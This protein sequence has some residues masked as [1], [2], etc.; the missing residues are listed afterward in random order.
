MI[1]YLNCII[2]LFLFSPKNIGYQYKMVYWKLISFWENHEIAANPIFALQ[3]SQL[4]LFQEL[5]KCPHSS[6]NYVIH[7]MLWK[8]LLNFSYIFLYFFHDLIL[9]KYKMQ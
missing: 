2:K 7:R 8:L 5:T 6:Q 1:Y 4:K 9:A 3:I